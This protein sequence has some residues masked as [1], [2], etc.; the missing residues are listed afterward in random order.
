M[1]VHFRSERLAAGFNATFYRQSQVYV[2]LLLFLEQRFFS[3]ASETYT[4]A[5]MFFGE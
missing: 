4:D 1:Q 5:L 2:T 3:M